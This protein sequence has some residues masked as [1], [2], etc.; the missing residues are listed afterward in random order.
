[1]SNGC[2]SLSGADPGLETGL[3]SDCISWSV[4]AAAH[5]VTNRAAVVRLLLWMQWIVSS[6]MAC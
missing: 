5:A 1:M 3:T 4:G 6:R 2:D